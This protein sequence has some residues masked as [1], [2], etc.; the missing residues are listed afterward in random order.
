MNSLEE[1]VAAC[2]SPQVRALVTEAHRCYSTGSARASIVLTWTAVCADV[3]EKLRRLAEDGDGDA[4]SVVDQIEKVQGRDDAEAIKT[5]QQ[6]ESGLLKNAADLE[7][8]DSVELRKLDQLRLDRNLCAHPALRPLGDLFEPTLDDARTHLAVALDTLL[9]HRPS[10]GQKVVDRF[11]A[12]VEEPAFAGSEA[13]IAHSFFDTVKP[14]VRRKIVNLAVKHA[15]LE[16]E[17]SGALPPA[18]LS[19][20]MSL[21]VYAF[22]GRDRPLIAQEVDANIDRLGTQRVDQQWRA[23][24]RLG[25]LDAFWETIPS[26]LVDQFS[27]SIATIQPSGWAQ[28]LDPDA[29]D[30]LA[31]ASR[32]QARSVLPVLADRFEAMTDFDQASIVSTRPGAYFA[33][34]LPRLMREAHTFRA[35]ESRC[36]QAVLPCAPYLTAEQ[37]T[38]LLQAWTDN[39]Q[40]RAAGGMPLLA[41]A[42]YTITAPRIPVPEVWRDFVRRACAVAEHPL[43]RYED[44]AAAVGGF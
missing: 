39:D 7:L 44:V 29:I 37:L 10:Q 33:S 22:A 28:T 12:H 14:V 20:R 11:C 42:L 2:W 8:I 23:M 4:R 3:I 31:L 19:Q 1:R 35:A 41:H 24:A 21:A 30:V 16:L 38:E 17:G 32:D 15:L 9:T 6:V 18:M 34:F 5:M 25:E 13:F 36:S 27:A 26:S 40:C 43:Y